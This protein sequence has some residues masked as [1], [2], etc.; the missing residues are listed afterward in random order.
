MLQD[1]RFMQ[2]RRRLVGAI[3]SA[4]LL[5][6]GSNL[7]AAAGG[8]IA[9]TPECRDDDEPTPRQ[10]E[11]PYFRTKSPQRQRLR[12]PGMA[13]RPLEISGIVLSTDCLPI[14][15]AKLDFWQCNHQGD[16]DNRGFVLRGHQ[17]TDA[18]GRYL[19]ETIE[20]ASYPGRTRHIHV[21]VQAP[22]QPVLT[23]QLYF[24]GEPG[25]Q[26]DRIFDSRMLMQ[27]MTRDPSGF[28]GRFDFV[29]AS[30]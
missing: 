10:T 6:F 1:R 20:P 3:A 4:P 5:V 19:L 26:R 12:E 14:A 29:L 7:R 8:N 16:Y 30:G 23:T 2:G 27:M 18:Q 13:G 17:F 9:P 25:N 21:K 11:G 24:P 15:G 22:Y 28:S